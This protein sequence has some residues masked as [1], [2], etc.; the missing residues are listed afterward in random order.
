MISDFLTRDH[1][2]CDE[3]FA[4]AEENAASGALSDATENFGRFH[5][6]MERHFSREESVLFPRLGEVASEAQGPSAVMCAE[7]SQMRVL[8]VEMEMLLETEDADT[9]L[10]G[11][12]TLLILMQQHNL[13]EESMLYPMADHALVQESESLMA[14]LRD[15]TPS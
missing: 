6:E 2:F 8:M 12:E 15:V 9:F 7:H 14:K 1:R 11:C 5:Q 3:L 4:Q 13:K 10:D